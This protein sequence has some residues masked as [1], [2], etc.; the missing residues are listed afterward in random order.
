MTIKVKHESGRVETTRYQLEL[1]AIDESIGKFA[2]RFNKPTGG[3]YDMMENEF[4]WT[5]ECP[6]FKGRRER[7]GMLCKH[8]KALKK[9]TALAVLMD[10]GD[11]WEG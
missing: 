10:R 2:V 4:G 5:C 8:L 9:T 1:L 11:A 3:S 7:W 6:D